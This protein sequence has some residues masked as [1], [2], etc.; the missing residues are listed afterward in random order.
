[1]T[2]EDTKVIFPMALKQPAATQWRGQA[3]HMLLPDDRLRDRRKLELEVLHGQGARYQY[4]VPMPN[5]LVTT[6]EA[7]GM[8]IRIGLHREGQ[9][10][11]VCTMGRWDGQRGIQ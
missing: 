4:N 7:E 3:V 6:A 1:M 10:V 2:Q 11:R 9:A 5:V 8:E